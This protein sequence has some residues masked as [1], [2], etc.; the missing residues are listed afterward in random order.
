M[1]F[2]KL[3]KQ[4]TVWDGGGESL[5]QG[6]YIQTFS[7][8]FGGTQ[9]APMGIRWEF[10]PPSCRAIHCGK[11]PAIPGLELHIQSLLF[12]YQVVSN[13]LWPRRL[14]HAR[15]PC[16]SLSTGDC[17][18]SCPL[19][20]WCHPTIPSSVFPISSCLQSFRASGFSNELSLCIRWPKYWS[21]SICPSNEYSGLISFR[22]DWF[23]FAV[24]GALKN[25]L[26]DRYFIKCQ[27]QV[28]FLLSIQSC[29]NTSWFS[30][31]SELRLL[32]S[33]GPW[34]WHQD[35]LEDNDDKV[36]ECVGLNR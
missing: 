33:L 6:Q 32:I 22:I 18:Y 2:L 30:F 21:F 25:L 17:S 11:N 23:D 36:W 27:T 12:S 9:G 34:A 14:Q 13:F 4:R 16:L 26:Q 8:C 31:H 7:V 5:L 1:C 20:W 35:Q 3:I 24:R 19:S 29:F 15:L 10:R 28:G